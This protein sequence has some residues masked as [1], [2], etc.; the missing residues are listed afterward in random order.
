MSLDYTLLAGN[1]RVT[2]SQEHRPQGTSSYPS[3][4]LSTILHTYS[5]RSSALLPTFLSL[6]YS[7]ISLLLILL[8][9]SSSSPP[10]PD[11]LLIIIHYSLSLGV[12]TGQ[13]QIISETWIPNPTED[14]K[15]FYC[16]EVL[17]FE[18]VFHNLYS[19]SI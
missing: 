15:M 3:H 9:T 19:R 16:T 18:L 12:V 17:K 1:G 13:C 8:L 14:L 5:P 6:S 7:S 10:S 11:P 4:A 2:R